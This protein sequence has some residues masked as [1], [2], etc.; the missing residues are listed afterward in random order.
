MNPGRVVVVGGGISGLATAYYLKRDA[1]ARGQNVRCTLYEAESRFGG[2]IVTHRNDGFVV[3]GA[4]DSFLTQKP[5]ALELARDLGLEDRLIGISSTEPARILVRGQ[6]RPIPSGMSLLVP[7]RLGPFLRSS[8]LSWPGKLRVLF[9]ALVP[10]RRG[11]A[12][13]SLASFVR[14][15]LG[16]EMLDVFGE[17][18]LAGV[19][20][21]DPE[22]L[23]VQS[24]FPR[25][26]EMERASGSLLRATWEARRAQ[27][28]S[29]KAPEKPRSPFVSFRDGMAE[30]TDALAAR[31]QGD[32]VSGRRVV[33]VRRDGAEGAYAVAL[34]DG[35]TIPAD[36]VVLAIPAYA[37]ADLLATVNSELAG[38]LREIR[39]VSTATV[40][41]GFRDADVA[42]PL[43][44]SGFV[45]AR[46][47]NRRIT[48]CT[49]SSSKFPHRAPAHHVLLRAFVGDAHDESA[50]PLD[51]PTLTCLVRD[52]LRLLMG[53]TAEPVLV[54]IFRWPRAMPQY[55][56]GHLE[57]VAA[58]EKALPPGVFLVGNAYRGIGIPDC[59]LGAR[60][61]A[62][63][64]STSLRPEK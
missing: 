21:A 35:T 10:P 25:F 8:I 18:L 55:D 7:S 30:L 41:L 3:E 59:V 44:S 24:T 2:R 5:W 52:E 53:I 26:P 47:E 1:A 50:L 33:G 22:R 4:P 29:G 31:L 9:E 16:R 57:R 28:R 15:R 19:H 27:A 54:D 43:R 17:P 42:M 23:S 13:E 6:L 40:S 14:R 49:W 61:T 34:D 39:Y 36:A 45:I 32:L 56:V 11:A 63:A 62:D 60:R 20:A 46:S 38:R 37:A 51:D 58:L 64:I 12:D 48:A